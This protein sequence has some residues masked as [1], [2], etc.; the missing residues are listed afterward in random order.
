LFARQSAKGGGAD[1]LRKAAANAAANAGYAA[2]AADTIW[3]E[4]S[5]DAQ[6]L[7]NHDKAPALLKQPLW[8]TAPMPAGIAA[9]W[10]AFKASAEAAEH[11]YAPWIAWYEALVPLP[12][13]A[14]PRNIFGAQLTRRIALQPKEWWERE[15]AAVNADLAKLLKT[16]APPADTKARAEIIKTAT[17]RRFAETA[18]AAKADEDDHL[19]GARPSK[20]EDAG[21]QWVDAVA[22]LENLLRGRK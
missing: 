15:P 16:A 9:G 10:A 4:V 13:H 17:D 2:N 12:P 8:T 21:R 18:K 20:K 6:W 22:A 7:T 3:R 11:G 1:E 19:R 14:A 5:T